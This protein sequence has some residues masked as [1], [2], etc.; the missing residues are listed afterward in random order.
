MRGTKVE[1]EKEKGTWVLVPSTLG[2]VILQLALNTWILK[3]LSNDSKDF[4]IP[5]ISDVAI[6]SPHTTLTMAAV[7]GPPTGVPLTTFLVNLQ[8]YIKSD[9]CMFLE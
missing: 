8:D 4:S 6:L 3:Y 5:E 1:G 7:D 2:P 9:Q